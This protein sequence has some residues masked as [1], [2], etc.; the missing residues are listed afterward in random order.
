MARKSYSDS[1]SL[2]GMFIVFLSNF[3]HTTE[4]GQYYYLDGDVNAIYKGTRM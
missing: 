3:G 4:M 2:L 1:K